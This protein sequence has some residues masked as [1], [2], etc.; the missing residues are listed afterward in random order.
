MTQ[1]E[2]MLSGRLYI[3]GESPELIGEIIRARK[4]IQE[5]NNA[6]V[7]AFARRGEILTELL[8]GIGEN[9]SINPP[10]RCD[11]GS[12]ITMGSHVF[13]N[14]DC[15]FIDVCPITI[16]DNVFFGPRVSLYTAGHPIDA[17][18]RNMELEFGRPI[19]IGSDVW[20]GGNVVVLPGVT[21]GNDV[22]VGAGSLV[23][24][25]IPDG[26]IAV[27]NPCRVL[28]PIT[29]ADRERWRRERD[30]YFSEM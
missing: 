22:V 11:Y 25:D 13:V 16:G 30:A 15:I 2:R 3:A 20:I 8:G 17:E 4:L 28:R 7:M 18:V 9:S 6:D 14:Y 5:F 1:K 12:N 10:F 19:A 29:D 21:I 27:G 24:R 26:V 23:T